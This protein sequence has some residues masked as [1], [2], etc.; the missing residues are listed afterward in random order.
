[1]TIE[2]KLIIATVVATIFFCALLVQG[3][4]WYV[5]AHYPRA[6]AIMAGDG[7]SHGR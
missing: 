3:G 6:A 7:A 2:T 1:M 4:N 5:A